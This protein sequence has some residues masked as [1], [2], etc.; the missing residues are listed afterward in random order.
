MKN[1]AFLSCSYIWFT[2]NSDFSDTQSKAK[3]KLPE[4]Q[5]IYKQGSNLMVLLASTKLQSSLAIVYLPNFVRSVP[6][7]QAA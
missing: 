2:G 7:N 5:F 1:K 6:G 3:F 4:L